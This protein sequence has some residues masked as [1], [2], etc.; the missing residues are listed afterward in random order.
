MEF[1]GLH[2]VSYSFY[3]VVLQIEYVFVVNL[4]PNNLAVLGAGIIQKVYSGLFDN[5]DL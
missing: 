3:E 5:I 1:G 2:F 4:L